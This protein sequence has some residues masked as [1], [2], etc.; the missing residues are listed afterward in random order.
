MTV[1]NGQ[2]VL[3]TR[4]YAI[5]RVAIVEHASVRHVTND[6]NRGGHGRPTVEV[7]HT[8]RIGGPGRW[9]QRSRG[10]SQRGRNHVIL[11]G[12][13]Y[14]RSSRV[15]TNHTNWSP[16]HVPV[17]ANHVLRGR[18]SHRNGQRVSRRHPTVKNHRRTVRG[19]PCYQGR[20]RGRYR[21]RAS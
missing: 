15:S 17:G 19:Y 7:Q 4:R 2:L 12:V 13:N 5:N 16:G 6:I 9:R 20:R 1:F 21:N 11:R 14:R 3:T 8:V 18:T 10:S